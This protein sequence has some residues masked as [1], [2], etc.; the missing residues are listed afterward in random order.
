MR[1]CDDECVDADSAVGDNDK[2]DTSPRANA[3]PAYAAEE[4]KIQQKK[5]CLQKQEGPRCQNCDAISDLRSQSTLLVRLISVVNV[6]LQVLM[7][8]PTFVTC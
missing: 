8:V 3:C 7:D 2:E 1:I 6:N 5:R 4:V